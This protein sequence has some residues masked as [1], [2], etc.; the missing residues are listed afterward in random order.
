[1]FISIF[2]D[3]NLLEALEKGEKRIE[4]CEIGFTLTEATMNAAIDPWVITPRERVK[5]QEQFKSLKPQND[6]VTG[7]QARGFFLQSQLSPMI[8][9]EIW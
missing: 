8:L 2:A 3:R 1:M 6:I 5:Y 4:F 7:Q 9:G